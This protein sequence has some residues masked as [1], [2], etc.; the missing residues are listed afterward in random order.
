[1]YNKHQR[2]KVLKINEIHGFY[3]KSVKRLWTYILWTTMHV[4]FYAQWLWT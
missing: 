3:D 1:M 2:E 4:F